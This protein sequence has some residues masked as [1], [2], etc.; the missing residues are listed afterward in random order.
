MR[1][2]KYFTDDKHKKKELEIKIDRQT[3]KE[4]GIVVGSLMSRQ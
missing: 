2:L 4:N 3:N 1:I